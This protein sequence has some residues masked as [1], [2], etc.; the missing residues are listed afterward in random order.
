MAVMAALTCQINTKKRGLDVTPGQHLALNW[1]ISIR[2]RP[3]I[4][5][6]EVR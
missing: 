4:I 2:G 3:A 1:G 6:Y 5:N